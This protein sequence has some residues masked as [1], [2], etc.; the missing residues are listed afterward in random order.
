MPVGIGGTFYCRRQSVG[1]GTS[2]FRLQPTAKPP[3]K[4]PMCVLYMTD[5]L[6]VVIT[7]SQRQYRTP[8]C[9]N[10]DIDNGNCQRGNGIMNAKFHRNFKSIT[11]SG[12]Q[13]SSVH[14]LY[15]C[16]M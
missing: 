15:A 5:G 16:V 2:Q 8:K 13:V 12:V 4:R 10:N 3:T 1:R 9:C 6:T 14:T 11:L 7:I